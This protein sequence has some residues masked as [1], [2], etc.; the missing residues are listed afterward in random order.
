MSF[1]IYASGNASTI[2][3]FYNI[4]NNLIKF[5]PILFIYDGNNEITKNIIKNKFKNYSFIYEEQQ[6]NIN[7]IHNYTSEHIHKK[8]EEYNI[9]YLL[10]FGNKILKK[11]LIYNYKNK[12]INFHPSLLPAFKGLN[13]I[14]QALNTNTCFIGNTAHFIDYGIDTGDIICQSI[15]DKNYYKNYEDVYELQY[16]LIKLVFKK[17]LKLNDNIN[18]YEDINYKNNYMVSFNNNF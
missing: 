3:K 10:V 11:N 14:D 4:N 6:K 16:P 17:I 7:R 8:L 9:D 18:I 1:A 2:L 5:P 13:A 12:I 15:I